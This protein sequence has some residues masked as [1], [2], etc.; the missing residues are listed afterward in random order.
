MC[1][2]SSCRCCILLNGCIVATTELLLLVLLNNNGLKL[3]YAGVYVCLRV[4]TLFTIWHF[5][6][7]CLSFRCQTITGTHTESYKQ[8]VYNFALHNFQYNIQVSLSGT[9]LILTTAFSIFLFWEVETTTT[10]PTRVQRTKAAAADDG[11]Q[12]I[13]NKK[14]QQQRNMNGKMDVRSPIVQRVIWVARWENHTQCAWMKTFAVH[15]ASFAIVGVKRVCAM[16]I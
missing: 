4:P 16:M 8:W 9:W 11:Q 5:I 1:W 15:F 12:F 13:K 14:Q 6:T 2:L 10:Q 7:L 3:L